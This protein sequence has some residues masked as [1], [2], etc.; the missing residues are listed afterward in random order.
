MANEAENELVCFCRDVIVPLASR[1]NAL[2]LVSASDSSVLAKCFQSAVSNLDAAARK[3]FSVLGCSPELRL[4]MEAEGSPFKETRTCQWREVMSQS[5]KWKKQQKY[6]DEVHEENG[7]SR[8][9][10]M[11]M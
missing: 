7:M 1:T 2:V 5:K 9:V 6:L 10:L 3:E 4:W 11:C 8:L